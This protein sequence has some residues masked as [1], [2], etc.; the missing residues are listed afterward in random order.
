M[1]SNDREGEAD[2]ASGTPNDIGSATQEAATTRTLRT[3]RARLWEDTIVLALRDVQ[4]R[5]AWSKSVTHGAGQ[6]KMCYPKGI[7]KLDGSAESHLG[8]MAFK[9][10]D[11]R[12]FLIE[13]K[14]QMRQVKD[15]WWHG[16]FKPKVLYKT[17][18]SVVNAVKFQ[19]SSSETENLILELSLRGHMIAFWNPGSQS[20]NVR[21]GHIELLPY[22]QAVVDSVDED[23][24]SAEG[25]IKELPMPCVHSY[26][27]DDPPDIRYS[28]DVLDLHGDDFQ[29]G[30]L[31]PATGNTSRKNIGPMGLSR[32]EFQTYVSYLTKVRTETGS[33]EP[34]EPINAVV[35]TADDG[36]F[37]VVTTT[38]ELADVL[39]PEFGFSPVLTILRNQ[40]R[41]KAKQ[42]EARAA[43]RGIGARNDGQG[44][45][46]R[47]RRTP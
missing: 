5:A 11:Q 45:V 39:D 34:G 46:K 6:P 42:H 28:L 12:F 18:G 35:Q 38:A 36:F 4:W 21:P 10:D 44:V 33:E 8:D 43:T 41:A 16:A 27:M 9:A 14:S 15:E 30:H 37:Q 19:A 47:R 2:K 17:L 13:V 20:G 22:L 7:V 26:L 40:R 24:I 32:D 23:T 29:I 25:L 31:D 3:R 1:N